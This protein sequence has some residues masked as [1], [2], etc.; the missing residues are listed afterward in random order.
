VGASLAVAVAGLLVIRHEA[1]AQAT[2]IQITVGDTTTLQLD[3]NSS[4]GYSWV[5]QD[6]SRAY[7][8]FVAVDV[9]GYAKPEI[10]PGERPLLGAAQKFQVLVTGIEAGHADLVFNYLKAG[11]K[12]P[13]RTVAFAVEVLD[14]GTPERD[15]RDTPRD[16][17]FSN[18][19]DEQDGGGNPD[20]F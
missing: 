11:E 10:K 16:D 17:L 20:R 14:D 15:A 19:G 13:A 12:T 6:S 3:G 2:P 1:L 9:L 5:L 8:A 7:F 18:P 4:T